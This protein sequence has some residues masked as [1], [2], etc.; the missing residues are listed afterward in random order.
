M[1]LLIFYRS[2][3]ACQTMIVI[4]EAGDLIIQVSEVIRE[5]EFEQ[6]EEI[7]VNKTGVPNTRIDRIEEFQVRRSTLVKNSPVFKVL[8]SPGRFAE[9]TQQT[10]TLKDDHIMSME[11]I[12]RVLHDASLQSILEVPI[13]E[14]WPL[15]LAAEKYNLDIKLFREWF[16]NW[17]KS[18]MDPSK[19][20]PAATLLYPCW[21]FNHASAFARATRYLAYHS[22]GPIMESNPTK[23]YELHLPARVIRES[24]YAI[25][26]LL[27]GQTFD[28]V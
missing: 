2:L 20:S 5:D 10:V 7:G 1:P 24:R 28:M 9:G 27:F 3:V 21:I 25:M 16:K 14:M 15:V 26:L 22:A 4:E 13:E 18:T 8:L 11:I 23:H 12:F 19:V 17:Y 6:D